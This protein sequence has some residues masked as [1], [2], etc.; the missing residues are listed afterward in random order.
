M[1]LLSELENNP[2]GKFFSSELYQVS[3]AYDSLVANTICH[4][5]LHLKLLHSLILQVGT[6]LYFISFSRGLCLEI[7]ILRYI[8]ICSL[9]ITFCLFL[10]YMTTGALFSF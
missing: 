4:D 9:Y 8:F 2:F 7:Y 5:I 3:A 6:S 10:P 1:Q